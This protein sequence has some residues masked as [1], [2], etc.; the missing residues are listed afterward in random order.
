MIRPLRTLFSAAMCAALMTQTTGAADLVPALARGMMPPPPGLLAPH[1]GA[2]LRQ[3]PAPKPAPARQG[4]R[5]IDSAKVVA[6]WTFTQADNLLRGG[7]A[8][9]AV[10][11]A[12]APAETAFAPESAVAEQPPHDRMLIRMGGMRVLAAGGEARLADLK[13]FRSELK[14]YRAAYRAA[15]VSGGGLTARVSYLKPFGVTIGD[16]DGFLVKLTGGIER[17][18]PR[19][20]GVPE[21]LRREFPVYFAHDVVEV[22]LT[23]RNDGTETIPGLRLAAVQETYSHDA[24]AGKPLSA[25]EIILTGALEPGQARVV[26]WKVKLGDEGT[27]VVNFEQTHLVAY[28]RDASGLEKLLLDKPQA[29]VID[30]PKF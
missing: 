12:A 29:G 13:T 19:K 23:L 6:R 7:P 21:A 26:R 8:P 14:P 28:S 15:P 25:P 17:Y 2:I 27:E 5:W 4:E 10:P 20:G 11:A 30:P 24:L 22:E 3:A 16:A 1:P 18:L 9:E